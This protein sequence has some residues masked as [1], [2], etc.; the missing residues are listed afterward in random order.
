MLGRVLP[1][2]ERDGIGSCTVATDLGKFRQVHLDVNLFVSEHN[3]KLLMR[4]C[5][6]IVASD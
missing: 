4:T 2:R 1:L 3:V 5:E 6:Y